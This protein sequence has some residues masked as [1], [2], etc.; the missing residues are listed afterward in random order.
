MEKEILSK[1]NHIIPKNSNTSHD[2]KKTTNQIH[3][4]LNRRV[5]VYKA[6]KK[7]TQEHGAVNISLQ[8]TAKED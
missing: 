7:T 4:F 1:K 8:K 6:L 2:K 3:T 5:S